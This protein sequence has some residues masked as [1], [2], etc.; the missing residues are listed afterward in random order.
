MNSL[1]T[2]RQRVLL[3]IKNSPGASIATIADEVGF[4]YE[5]VRQQVNALEREGWVRSEYGRGE[6][7]AVGRP[8]ARYRLTMAGE[9][10]FPKQYDVL[11]STLIATAAKAM[12][13][14]AVKGLLA[15]VTAEQVR[16]WRP[17]LEGLSLDEKLEKL[18]D[19]YQRDDPYVD[20]DRTG[21]ELRLI[22]R[23]CPFL[24][25]AMEHPE[26]CSISVST[27]RGLLGYHV[28]RDERF[29]SGHGRCV[30]RI[31]T[32]R[33]VAE[34]EAGFELEEVKGAQ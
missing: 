20:V 6:K 25:T 15:S 32:S 22:E 14:E 11:A 34:V 24:S 3:S 31:D 19:L 5:A 1:G 7:R 10:L 27:L 18:R 12:G 33:P 21:S 26:L 17:L 16:R 28:V 9:H 29:Q 8:L 4:T 13:G 30:F 2:A 23:N